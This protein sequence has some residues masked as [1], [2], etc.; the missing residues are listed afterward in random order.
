MAS[1]LLEHFFQV[2]DCRFGV[3]VSHHLIR[4]WVLDERS[5]PAVRVHQTAECE[6]IRGTSLDTGRS[7][8]TVPDGSLFIFGMRVG[9]FNALYTK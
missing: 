7:H 4:P 6:R 5:H 8:F 3:Q 9:D 2:D 1:Y